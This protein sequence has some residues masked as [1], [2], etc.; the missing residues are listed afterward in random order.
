MNN[1]DMKS[2]SH[3]VLVTPEAPHEKYLEI[4]SDDEINRFAARI[5][6]GTLTHVKIERIHNIQATLGIALDD[7]L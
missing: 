7:V 3:L 1:S 6:D 4:M 5:E 2:R